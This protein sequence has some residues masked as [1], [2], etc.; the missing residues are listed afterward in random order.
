MIEPVKGLYE[1]TVSLIDYNSL[2]PSI[3]RKFNICFLTVERPLTQWNEPPVQLEEG[4]LQQISCQENGGKASVLPMILNDLI[5]KRREIQK[6]LKVEYR[7]SLHIKQLALKL[8]ANSIYGILGFKNSR[9]YSVTLSPL[10]TFYGRSILIKTSEFV[11]GLGYRV[12]YGD[13]DSIMVDLN[14]GNVEEG[15]GRAGAIAQRINELDQS[16]ILQVSVECLFKKIYL[17]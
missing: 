14:T 12:I 11:K 7:E 1:N 2:Y 9:F 15:V 3:I 8:V 10:I 17:I 4:Q 5:L 13:T 16:G 6:E